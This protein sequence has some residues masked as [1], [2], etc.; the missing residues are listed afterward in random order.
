[1]HRE[2]TD[3]NITPTTKQQVAAGSGAI[4]TKDEEVVTDTDTD[5]IPVHTVATMDV[6]PVGP[7]LRWN[8]FENTL[9]Q[10]REE[11]LESSIRK[12]KKADQQSSP[13]KRRKAG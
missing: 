6:S 8:A 9:R 4:P 13:S 12:A 10:R 5:M 7:S 1:M 3:R 2:A 11:V